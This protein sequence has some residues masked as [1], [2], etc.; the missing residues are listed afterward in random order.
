MKCLFSGLKTLELNLLPQVCMTIGH[1]GI[2]TEIIYLFCMRVDWER[3]GG[4]RKL[5]IAC[6]PLARAADYVFWTR[7][8]LFRWDEGALLRVRAKLSCCSEIPCIVFVVRECYRW[9]ICCCEWNICFS[10]SA[11]QNWRRSASLP[12]APR[13]CACSPYSGMAAPSR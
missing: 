1:Y 9:R 13:P 10:G 11:T 12:S 7:A 3:V 4:S 5:Y 6:M 8:R 2:G